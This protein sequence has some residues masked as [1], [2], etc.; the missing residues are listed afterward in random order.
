M[1]MPQPQGVNVPPPP[2][3]NPQP[4]PNMQQAMAQQ[5]QAPQQTSLGQGPL[6]SGL[7]DNAMMLTKFRE[8][9][10]KMATQMA[11]DGQEPP[12]FVDWVK[13]QMPQPAQQQAPAAPEGRR[14]MLTRM[15]NSLK[16]I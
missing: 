11:M 16:G 8:P 7:A 5:P 3:P 6:G 2:M 15:I 10:M 12:P 14:G 13:S 4:G 9:Y 1:D